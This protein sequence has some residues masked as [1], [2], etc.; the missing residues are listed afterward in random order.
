MYQEEK[1]LTVGRQFLL[2]DW[3]RQVAWCL[4]RRLKS[5]RQDQGHLICYI[6][7]ETI[8][9]STV[10]YQS[11]RWVGLTRCGGRGSDG[12]NIY[13]TWIIH[14]QIW[15]RPILMSMRFW[16]LAGF[17]RIMSLL[18]WSFVVGLHWVLFCQ[19]TLLVLWEHL[20][21]FL[22]LKCWTWIENVDWIKGAQTLDRDALSGD[23]GWPECDQLLDL[24]GKVRP[25]G[26]AVM[27]GIAGLKQKVV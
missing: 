15:G 11:G 27:V 19:N 25:R 18:W 7:A 3:S 1:R 8:Y 10:I 2:D 13:L 16:E 20:N 23:G 5:C 12:W 9:V 26:W 14:C 21:L 4:R 6:R 17:G 22:F 24:C